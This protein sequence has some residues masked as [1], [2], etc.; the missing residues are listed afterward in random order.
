M[1]ELNNQP[2]SAQTQQEEHERQLK[3][4]EL[5]RRLVKEEKKEKNGWKGIF[6]AVILALAIRSF[7]FEP[8]NIPSS[9]MV[10]T[11]FVGDYLFITKFDYG[12][13]RH[14]FP[15]SVPLIPRGKFGA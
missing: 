5:N 10:P 9:S 2:L 4:E 12:Y 14:S 3:I 15:L 1:E 11:L 13:S 7:L 6:G 8:Y